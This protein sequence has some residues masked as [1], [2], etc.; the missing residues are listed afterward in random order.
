MLSIRI[1]ASM[2]SSPGFVFFDFIRTFDGLWQFFASIIQRTQI[3]LTITIL[4]QIS[5]KGIKERISFGRMYA[6]GRRRHVRS[7]KVYIFLISA[8]RKI[9]LDVSVCHV[10]TTFLGDYKSTKNCISRFLIYCLLSP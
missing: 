9:D 3:V 4:S 8:K 7:Y 1:E 6:A 2:N 5:L 10:Q